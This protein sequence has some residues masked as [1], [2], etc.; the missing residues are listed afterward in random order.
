M[1][2]YGNELIGISEDTYEKLTGEKISLKNKEIVYITS[3]YRTGNRGGV[4]TTKGGFDY[5]KK[6][7]TWLAMGS[8]TSKLKEYVDPGTNNILPSH[9]K[10]HL[11]KLK[12]T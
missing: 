8:Y 9:D 6:G 1:S 10:K 5:G 12:K 7:F 2:S 11:Y 3:E 4:D